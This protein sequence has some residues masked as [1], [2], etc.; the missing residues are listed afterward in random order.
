[1]VGDQ[2]IGVQCGKHKRE[3]ASSNTSSGTSSESELPLHI[4]MLFMMA[5]MS[6]LTDGSDSD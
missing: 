6:S 5:M 4:R 1:M 3:A 2:R